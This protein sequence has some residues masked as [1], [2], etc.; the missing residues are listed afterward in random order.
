MDSDISEADHK[1][2]RRNHYD[3]EHQNPVRRA[4]HEYIPRRHKLVKRIVDLSAARRNPNGPENG[5]VQRGG[6]NHVRSD[7][8]HMDNCVKQAPQVVCGKN[9]YGF[10]RIVL[11]SDK[12]IK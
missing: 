1:M 10:D 5:R 4:E 7:H 6:V 12:M 11:G 9:W 3:K 2:R 8:K